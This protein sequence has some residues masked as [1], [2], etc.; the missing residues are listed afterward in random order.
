MAK[1]GSVR[2]VF[3]PQHLQNKPTGWMR[4]GLGSN[5]NKE[6]HHLSVPLIGDTDMIG[7]HL[8]RFTDKILPLVPT[9]VMK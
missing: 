5:L 1:Y 7:A 6:Q 2:V 4:G 8:L 9:V 3:V